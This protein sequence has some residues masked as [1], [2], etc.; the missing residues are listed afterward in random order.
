MTLE[1]ARQLVRVVADA[2]PDQ[3]LSGYADETWHD[4]L[5]ELPYADC[6]TAVRALI[7]H[8]ATVAPAD[9]RTEIGPLRES[10]LEQQLIPAPPP[11]VADDPIRYINY[12]RDARRRTAN[13]ETTRPQAER[14]PRPFVD[15]RNS[16]PARKPSTER[17]P[18]YVAAQA[19]LANLPDLGVALVDQARAQ[20]GDA[21]YEDLVIHA[22]QTACN[23]T[24]HTRTP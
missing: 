1:E 23:R 19:Y 8:S 13:G 9:I 22:H 2:C 3:V 21:P 20:H 14:R 5:G 11:D 7:R 4:L 16:L 17:D 18:Q 12:L 10:R 15:I 24:N 6:L